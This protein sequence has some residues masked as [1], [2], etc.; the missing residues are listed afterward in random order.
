MATVA[1]TEGL[2]RTWQRPAGIIGW[3][4]QVNH[5]AVA[6]RYVTTAFVFFVLAG[7]GALIMRVQLAQPNLDVVS[8]QAY[9][10]LF[11][12]HGTTMM[13]LFAI[14]VLEGVAMYL[15]PL[16]IG[17]RDMVFPRLNAFGYWVFLLAGSSLY[18]SP[19]IDNAPDGGWFMYVPLTTDRFSPGLGIDFWTTSITFLK[20]AALVAATE[21]I[22]T[23]FKSRAPGMSLNRMPLFVWAI[24]VTSFMIIVAMPA[25]MLASVFLAL[26]RLIGTHFFNV[27]AGGDPLLWQHLFWIFGHPEVYIILVPA[28]GVVSTIVSTFARQPNAAYVLVV[29]S[30]VATG[31][32][33]FGLWVH[34]MFTTGLPWLGMSFFAAGSMLV[35]IPSGI[36]VFSWIATLWR[37]RPRLQ[38]PFL[39]VL[40]FLF[41][42]VLGGITGVMVGS[43]PFDEQVHDTHFV[44]AHFH[45]VLIGGAVFPLFGAVYY[46]FP[47][48]TGRLL[49][50]TMGKSSFWLAFV[51]FNL[52]FFPLHLVG[53]RG[54]PRRYYTYPEALG[55][56][57][58]NL[59]SSVSAFVLAAGFGLTF[60]NMF[61]SWRNGAEAGANP[62]GA[63]TLE[64]AVPSPPPPYN[65]AALPVVRH[66]YPL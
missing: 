5:K 20:I 53:F 43:I 1:V 21:L 9:N 13:F 51:G 50:E 54:M 26:D 37:T 14:P 22:V 48:V 44:V 65:F 42:F 46:W 63:G 41:I 49:S 23:I 19:I 17:A 18:M 35:T 12:M 57:D 6:V 62:W 32:I 36:Q 58:L 33:S 27:A 16:M 40:G 47:K 60:V 25:V 55:V 10:E 56:G 61:W 2:T 7:I 4:S 24:L 59:L 52:T 15:V 34:H 45:Y 66:R 30:L 31:F 64:W 39:W 38:T 29:L 3:L 11:T 28:L 8:P